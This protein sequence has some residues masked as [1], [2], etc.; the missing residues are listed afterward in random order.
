[1]P[2][3]VLGCFFCWFTRAAVQEERGPRKRKLGI[4]ATT[5]ISPSKC[6]RF[7]V[8]L[9]KATSSLS[10]PRTAK[11]TDCIRRIQSI[12]SALHLQI[13]SQILVTC[14]QQAKANENFRHFDMQQ[15]HHI[16][17]HVWSE[18]F[19]L[20]AAHWT[21][22]IGFIIE[23]YVYPIETQA[24]ATCNKRLADGKYLQIASQIRW[25]S[26]GYW[27]IAYSMSF[28]RC[29][30]DHL[31][32][33]YDETKKLAADPIE[34]SLMETLILCRKGAWVAYTVNRNRSS[35]S[36]VFHL[37]VL[38]NMGWAPT[39]AKNWNSSQRV[40]SSHLAITHCNRRSGR[41]LENCCLVSGAFH[42]VALTAI[43]KLCSTQS[44]T[45]Y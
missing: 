11:R 13:L 29:N 1:M 26:W 21:I 37:V 20:R 25:C 42:Y 36:V 27:F 34:L 17:R 44:S 40:R 35:L 14:L 38:Q 9:S 6:A 2:V 41:G 39:T 7:T 8:S 16:L 4:N 5:N 10:P 23:R 43:C 18:C 31:K 22:D 12:P 3:Y 24:W 32:R 15:Q 33:I 45:I 30:D 19:V 28:D